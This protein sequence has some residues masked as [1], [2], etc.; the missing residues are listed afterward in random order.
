MV[1]PLE[2]AAHF[3]SVRSQLL[4]A[5][6]TRK[7]YITAQSEQTRA[8]LSTVT[9]VR[10]VKALSNSKITQ[11]NIT[12]LILLMFTCWDS[13]IVL[14]LTHHHSLFHR[15]SFSFKYSSDW[16]CFTKAYVLNEDHVTVSTVGTSRW[17]TC[18][19]RFSVYHQCWKQ[20][21]KSNGI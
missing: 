16:K 9:P 11:K 12:S 2:S 21:R 3:D 19:C 10:N 14:H 4:P 18:K 6:A 5:H 20:F 8:R 15:G 1:L 7:G 13:Y 17:N